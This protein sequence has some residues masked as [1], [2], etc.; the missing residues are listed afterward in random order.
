[1]A[2]EISLEEAI[3]ALLRLA[4]AEREERINPE[5]AERKTEILLDEVGLSYGQIAT[6]VGKKPD[7][8]RKTVARAKKKT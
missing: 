8:V 1:M 3:T 4:V 5:L 7:A 2:D 6:L